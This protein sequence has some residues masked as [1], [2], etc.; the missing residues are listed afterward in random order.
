MPIGLLCL[1]WRRELLG[2]QPRR[3]AL[4]LTNALSPVAAQL[5]AFPL[6]FL[7]TR[8]RLD[9]FGEFLGD[10]RFVA[11]R[12]DSE[13]GPVFEKRRRFRVSDEDG[14]NSLIGVGPGALKGTLP[15]AILLIPA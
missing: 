1:S 7:S 10:F 11:A 15:F 5:I 2:F 14:D 3:G 12:F 9:H 8:V 6:R 13:R 4:D